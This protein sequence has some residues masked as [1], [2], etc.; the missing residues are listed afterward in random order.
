MAKLIDLSQEIFQGMPVYPGH[1]KT[2]IWDHHSHEETGKML[3]GE[4]S[5][6]TRGLM[7]SDHGPTHVDAVS[8]MD[9]DPNAEAINELPLEKF[10]TSGIA[11]DLSHI[12]SS[13]FISVNDLKE[14]L[15]KANLEIKPGDTVLLYTGHYTRNYGTEN[16]LGNYAGLD[17]E[18]TAWIAEQG[19]VNVGVDA[20]SIDNPI[21]KTYPSHNACV[22]YKLLN[23]ENLAD[24]R[25]VVGKR[26]QY[27]GLPLKI[28]KG[29]GSPVRAIAV[30]EDDK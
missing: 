24:L 26:F 2:V 23:V 27:I 12:P 22:K 9:P 28:R 3:K 15:E 25:P 18:A 6:A 20:P 21:D 19:A 16:W 8:H 30:L 1:V 29:T 5:Y 10:Y 11:L 4:F 14:A 17:Y 7:L 13:G